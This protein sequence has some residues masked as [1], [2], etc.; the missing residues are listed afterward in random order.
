MITIGKFEEAM[1]R[2]D[3]ANKKDPNTEQWQDKTYP[4]EYLY[5]I[6]MTEK[7]NS[8][9]PDASQALQLAARCQHIQRWQIPRDTYAT[10]RIG[11]LKWRQALQKFHVEK[12]S[13]ILK[14]VGYQ[15]EIIDQVAFLLQKKQLFTNPGTQTLE[16]VV[17]LVFLEY[18]FTDF[19]AKHPEEKQLEV[20]KKTW[21]KMSVEGQKA[22][23]K[24]PLSVPVKNIITKAING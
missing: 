2:F 24:L 17:C 15:Q 21:R 7:L 10:G 3:A 13:T 9:A 5:A 16:D 18:Y 12:A 4:K 14:E 23:L 22:A 6:R 20:L 8:F 11:Y 1:D 19:S